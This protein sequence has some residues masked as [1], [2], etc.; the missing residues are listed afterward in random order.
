MYY[1]YPFAIA[2]TARLATILLSIPPANQ[3]SLLEEPKAQ[4]K[5]VPLQFYTRIEWC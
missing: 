3:M 1:K 5:E 4:Q 2:L